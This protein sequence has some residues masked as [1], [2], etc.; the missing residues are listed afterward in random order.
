[1]P[2]TEGGLT[3]KASG[4]LRASPTQGVKP[5]SS[6]HGELQHVQHW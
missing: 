5:R 6:M 1:M 4:P 3:S 2:S